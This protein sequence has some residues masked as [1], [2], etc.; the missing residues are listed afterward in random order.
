M[1]SRQLAWLGVSLGLAAIIAAP[2]RA[3]CTASQDAAVQC[4]VANAVTTN[5]LSPR[6]GMTLAQFK[7][8]GVA[9]SKILQD[10]P[11]YIVLLGMAGAVSD[12]MP[13]TNADGSPNVAA[14]Q[15]AVDSIVDAELAN[16]LIS[17]SPEVDEQD[18]QWFSLDL[19]SAMNESTGVIVSPGALLRVV[20]SYIIS[21]TTDGQV[22]WTK[23]NNSLANMVTA[24]V[25][26]HLVKLPPAVSLTQ[27]VTLAQSLAQIIHTYKV[28]T[29]RARL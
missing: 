10:Q 5:L 22:N 25:H 4:F 12:A 11:T 14:Q 3:Q 17:T 15:M 20:D 13:A 24:L 29:G 16:N 21:A 2:A 8:Y 19:V 7:T 6:Y 1:R 26:T 27:A 23:A 9:V 18:L 28:A